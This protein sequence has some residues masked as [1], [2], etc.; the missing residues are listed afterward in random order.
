MV[1]HTHLLP[2]LRPEDFQCTSVPDEFYNC[3]AYAAG[4]EDEWWE[5]LKEDA[6]WPDHLPPDDTPENL[7]K[8]YEFVGFVRTA[9]GAPEPGFD[10]IAIYE[11]PGANGYSH[12]ARLLPDGWWTSKLGAEDDIRH[13]TLECLHSDEL[14]RAAYFM[15]RPTVG[16]PSVPA[17]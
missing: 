6:W 7:I 8:V 9:N 2:N 1:I 3:L 5:P 15:K 13:R 4:I 16:T 17:P 11:H 12:A 14:G 10:K